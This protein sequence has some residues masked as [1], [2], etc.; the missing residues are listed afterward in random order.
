MNDTQQESP[1]SDLPTDEELLCDIIDAVKASKLRGTSS[2]SIVA[3][4]TNFASGYE[5]G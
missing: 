3:T 5:R 1:D 4:L 2:A